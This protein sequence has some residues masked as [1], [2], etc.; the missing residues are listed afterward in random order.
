MTYYFVSDDRYLLTGLEQVLSGT[1]IEKEAVFI[2][3][4]KNAP[5]FKAEPEDVVVISI[6]NI[7][8][9]NSFMRNNFLVLSKVI[10]LVKEGLYNTLKGMR[11]PWIIAYSTSAQNLIKILLGVRRV[12][13]HPHVMKWHNAAILS[14]LG[15]GFSPQHVSARL[16]LPCKRVYSVTR[17]IKIQ[18]GLRNCNSASSILIC[19]DMA[20]LSATNKSL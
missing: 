13:V 7:T 17:E 19:R 3:V 5:S 11:S 20:F 4:G 6:M 1:V 18:M 16:Q 12:N 2:C 8:Q 15:K 9:R 10:I 14:V